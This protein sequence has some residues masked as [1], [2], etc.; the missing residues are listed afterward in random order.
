MRSQI[1]GCCGRVGSATL[2]RSISPPSHLSDA[3]D[4]AY[5]AARTAVVVAAAAAAAAAAA[6]N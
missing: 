3:E 5:A 1:A 6:S 4:G 2:G